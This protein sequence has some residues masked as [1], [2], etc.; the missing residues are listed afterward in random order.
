MN[1]FRSPLRAIRAFCLSCCGDSA[2]EVGLCV[3][4]HTCS[5]WPFRLGHTTSRAGIGKIAN[6]QKTT[7]G[8]LS[9]Q[10]SR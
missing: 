6:L 1:K 7:K 10:N 4:E 2:Q 5:L 8:Q 3:S 9:G